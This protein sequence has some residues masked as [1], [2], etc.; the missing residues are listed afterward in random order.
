MWVTWVVA[1]AMM[2]APN[3][4]ITQENGMSLRLTVKATR[5]TGMEK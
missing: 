3:S 1:Q 4:A 2:K 5:N